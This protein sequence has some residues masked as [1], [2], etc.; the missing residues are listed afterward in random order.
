MSTDPWE[1][2]SELAPEPSPEPEETDGAGLARLIAEMNGIYA[3]VSEGGSVLAFR[4]QYDPVLK[5]N[6]IVR[7]TFGAL[8]SLLLNKRLTVQTKKGPVTKTHADWWLPHA[9]RRTYQDGI[10]FDPTGNAGPT[11]FN[12]WGG[13]FVEP[14]PGD[15]SLMREHI[16]IVLCGGNAAHFDY[17][18]GWLARW[19]PTP[20]PE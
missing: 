15:W 12:L 11:F 6:V 13:F 17:F 16:R 14:K 19:L 7:M 8:K 9:M 2:D 5:R 18:M 3:V 1:D 4:Q 10:V 20:L